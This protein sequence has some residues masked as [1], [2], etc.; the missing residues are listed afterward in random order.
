MDLR[1]GGFPKLITDKRTKY[2]YCI[3]HLSSQ[4]SC[5]NDSSRRNYLPRFILFILKK[6]VI[7]RCSENKRSQETRR[8]LTGVQLGDRGAIGFSE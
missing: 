5:G 3:A 1:T 6:D 2:N 8:L 7:A 4:H